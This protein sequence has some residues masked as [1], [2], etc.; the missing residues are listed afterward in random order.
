M[1]PADYQRCKTCKW[2]DSENVL[3]VT[4]HGSC[5]NPKS[6][7][8]ES[9]GAGYE[10]QCGSYPSMYSPFTCGPDFGCVHWEAKDA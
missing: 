10:T 9:D 3:I 8:E 7:S 4:Q 1:N 2:W 5:T 6:G